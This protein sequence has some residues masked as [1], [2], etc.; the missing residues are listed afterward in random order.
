MANIEK[1]QGQVV[2]LRRQLDNP[3]EVAAAI[4]DTVNQGSD[5]LARIMAGGDGFQLTN[6]ENVT[7]HHYANALFNI[8]RGGVFD[9]QY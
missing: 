4:D 7:A 3:A 5:E 8:L 2:E 1:T 6:E 9:E